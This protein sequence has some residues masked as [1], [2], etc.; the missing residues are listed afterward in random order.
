MFQPTPVEELTWD[1]VNNINFHFRHITNDEHIMCLHFSCLIWILLSINLN[2]FVVI[3]C[4]IWKSE[5]VDSWQDPNTGFESLLKSREGRRLF[6]EFLK[7]EFSSENIQFWWAVEQLKS[8][9]GGDKIFRQHVDVIFKIYIND[10]ALAEVRFD[11]FLHFPRCTLR[12][13]LTRRWSKIWC[14]RKKIRPGTSL[15]RLKPR[16]FPLCTGIHTLGER[17]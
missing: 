1:L 3:I 16:F 10:T 6:E 8:L 5:K 14:W 2:I 13:A 17:I 15:R 7:K 9:R 4:L 11:A 12:L